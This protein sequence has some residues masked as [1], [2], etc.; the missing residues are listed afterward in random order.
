MDGA[1]IGIGRRQIAIL[2]SGDW[3]FWYDATTNLDKVKSLTKTLSE[4]AKL[5][6]EQ[7]DIIT[8]RINKLRKTIDNTPKT[9]NWEKGRNQQAM[10]P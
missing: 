1:H 2:L 8:E 7:V 10:V 6:E 4:F 9:K 5:S 3:G